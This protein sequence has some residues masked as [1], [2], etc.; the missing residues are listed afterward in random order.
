MTTYS[1]NTVAACTTSAQ[2]QAL[3]NEIQNAL[4]SQCGLAQL[5]NLMDTG[6]MA[7]PSTTAI[8]GAANTSQGYYVFAFNDALSLGP[9]VTGTALLSLQAGTGYN[10][11]AS[12]TFNNVALSGGT[13]AGAQATVV[14]GAS[15]V[16]TSITPTTAGTGYCIGDELTVTSAHMVAAGAAAGGSGGGAFVGQLTAAAAPCVILLEFGS[17]NAATDIQLWATV[18]TSWTSNGVVGAPTTRAC[19]FTGNVAA[20]LTADYNSRY[21]YN[22]TYGFLGLVFKQGALSVQNNSALG[23][24]F[25]FRTSSNAGTPNGNGMAVITA[26]A[27]ASSPGQAIT[28]GTMQVI[29]YT[30]ALV[31]PPLSTNNSTQWLGWNGAFGTF[32][33]GLT[34]TVAAGEATVL[35]IYTIDPIIRFS[36]VLGVALQQDFPLNSQGQFAIIGASTLTFLS[37]GNPWGNSGFANQSLSA[38]NIASL[39]M[40]W[41]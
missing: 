3:V 7:V 25:V 27:S 34:T 18:G 26:G 41:Q 20:S 28:N 38:G 37:L 16:I 12:G 6:Q 19:V 23:A 22:T 40:L 11:G 2:F 24:L 32:V 9:L 35:P 8:A 30:N 4:V 13:G 33:F 31:Y 29:S 17:G 10:G 1:T 15:G 39:V 14:L 21:C 5:S 36:A